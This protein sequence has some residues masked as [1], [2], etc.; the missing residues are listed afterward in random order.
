MSIASAMP[1]LQ[2]EKTSANQE[3]PTV[4]TLSPTVGR[5]R[6]TVHGSEPPRGTSWCFSL[7]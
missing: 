2:Q 6:P 5:Y 3:P 1:A 4:P 7:E